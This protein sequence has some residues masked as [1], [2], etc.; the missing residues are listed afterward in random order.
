[1]NWTQQFSSYDMQMQHIPFLQENLR[2]VR[3]A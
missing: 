3:S 2:T 1:M